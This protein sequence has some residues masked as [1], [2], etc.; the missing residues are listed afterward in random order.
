MLVEIDYGI[1]VG[2]TQFIKASEVDFLKNKNEL[3]VR[4][5]DSEEYYIKLSAV[6]EVY[7]NGEPLCQGGSYQKRL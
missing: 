1:S 5:V 7:L 6:S 2:R 4:S 3:Y